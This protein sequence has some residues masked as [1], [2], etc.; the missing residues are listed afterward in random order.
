MPIA[1]KCMAKNRLDS[2]PNVVPTAPP[3]RPAS[4][5]LA[6]TKAPSPL[7]ERARIEHRV[8]PKPDGDAE[9]AARD[10]PPKDSPRYVAVIA[11]EDGHCPA[12]AKHRPCRHEHFH[13]HHNPHQWHCG[14]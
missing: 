14:R 2:A 11:S 3:S 10:Q 1:S 5:A 13:R 8:E 6:T 7:R 12:E 9:H 4:R